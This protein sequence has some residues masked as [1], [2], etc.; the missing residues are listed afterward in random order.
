MILAYWTGKTSCL[1]SKYSKRCKNSRDFYILVSFFS[2]GCSKSSI[3]E[4]KSVVWHLKVQNLEILF[5]VQLFTTRRRWWYLSMMLSYCASQVSY[6]YILNNKRTSGS[7]P[8]W[9][10]STIHLYT[11][12]FTLYTIHYTLYTYTLI[13]YTLIYTYTY[14]SV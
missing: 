14:I 7:R 4:I 12:H 2:M 5:K 11:I 13:H 8:L 6:L 9:A 10:R 3:K 1:D